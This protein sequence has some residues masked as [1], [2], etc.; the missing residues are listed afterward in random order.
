MSQHHPVSPDIEDF[1]AEL[2][3]QES[4]PA[5][6]RNYAADLR[7]FARWFTDS[8]GEAFAGKV[9]TATDLRDY[10]AYLR[11]VE[12]RQ[13]ATVNRRLAALRRFFVWAK[14]AGKI[15]ELPTE[16]VRGVPAASRTPKALAKRDVDRLI[17]E[18]ERHADKR[19]LAILL[20]LRH[21]GLRVSEL[22]NLRLGVVVISER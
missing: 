2:L 10:K 4:S 15:A 18:A 20:T 8:T 12:Q 13:A 5:T 3:R 7:V 22:C 9:V 11:T 6:V 14:G 17:R 1:V 21:T 16:Q 19:N